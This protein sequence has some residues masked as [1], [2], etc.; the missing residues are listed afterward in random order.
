MFY[1]LLQQIYHPRCHSMKKLVL[2]LLSFLTTTTLIYAVDWTGNSGGNWNIGTNWTGGS[3][4]DSGD[5]VFIRTAD[6]V[7]QNAQNREM[8]RLSL[9]ISTNGGTTHLTPTLNVGEF[10]G[11]LTT[12]VGATNVNN[13]GQNSS[14]TT[15]FNLKGG[16]FTATNF[17]QIGAGTGNMEV[18]VSAGAFKL[19]DT[20]VGMAPGGTASLNV[21][22]DDAT[23]QLSRTNFGSGGTLSFEFGADGVSSVS[24]NYLIAAGATLLVDLT[25]YTGAAGTFTIVE[26]NRDNAGSGFISAFSTVTIT[27]GAYVGSSISQNLGTH[28]IVLTVVPEPGSIALLGGL[29]AL[30]Y[31]MARRR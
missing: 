17:T 7:F 31:V 28:E 20:N 18:N 11:S 14:G 24:M 26:A 10:N 16:G 23:L 30:F 29:F 1:L 5:A 22:G 2:T 21:I 8:G 6:T 9:G 19:A 25:D 15:T 13:W 3:V 27:E 4:P 12:G